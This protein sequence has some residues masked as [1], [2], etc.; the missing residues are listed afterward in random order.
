M[1]NRANDSSQQIPSVGIQPS[2]T[3]TPPPSASSASVGPTIII[4]P[5]SDIP[6]SMAESSSQVGLSAHDLELPV[7]FRDLPDLPEHPV[8]P[9]QPLQLPANDRIEALYTDDAYR[10]ELARE[11]GLTDAAQD[12]GDESLVRQV[13]NRD[14]VDSIWE[15][16]PEQAEDNYEV[17]RDAVSEIILGKSFSTEQQFFQDIRQHIKDR[18]A[19]SERRLPTWMDGQDV[20]E[21]PELGIKAMYIKLGHNR[22]EQNSKHLR[23]PIAVLSDDQLE[24]VGRSANQTK[25]RTELSSNLNLDSPVD[26]V[27]NQQVNPQFATFLSGYVLA[28][29]AR[30]APALAD[31]PLMMGPSQKE[32]FQNSWDDAR[33]T[34][35]SEGNAFEPNRAYALAVAMSAF[36]M[37]HDLHRIGKGFNPS[38]RTE[39]YDSFKNT[40]VKLV[41]TSVSLVGRPLHDWENAFAHL[42]PDGSYRANARDYVA[43]ALQGVA[44]SNGASEVNRPPEGGNSYYRSGLLFGHA[45][46]L[47]QGAGEFFI[48][49]DAAGTGGVL[50]VAGAGASSTGAGALAGIPAIV[51]GGV[52]VAGGAALAAHGTVVGG[53]ALG[54]LMQDVVYN[55]AGSD[56]SGSTESK[57]ERSAVEKLKVNLPSTKG[58]IGETTEESVRIKLQ[59]YLLNPDHTKGGPKAKWFKQALGF[60]RENKDDLAKQFLFKDSEAVQTGITEFGVK[61]NQTI[62]IV[63]ANGRVIPVKIAW[64]RN[65]DGVVRLITAVPGD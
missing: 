24:L 45:L 22:V 14:L 35:L 65:D 59:D 20:E 63:G 13:I 54:H 62:N 3:I 26:Y 57:G 27:A 51:G 42:D 15:V 19:L 25:K 23:R 56:G 46:G 12:F 48:G 6:G 7:D 11:T 49:G 16:G 53:R 21:V 17:R 50:A 37:L 32:A 47:V 1:I 36:P 64:I 18:Q 9:G 4:P 10:Q 43:G 60:T 28:A 44:E 5:T 2:A 40:M 61:F 8:E 33:E 34:A 39:G 52:L 55:S 30:E 29:A 58:W 38:I 41:K 31:A